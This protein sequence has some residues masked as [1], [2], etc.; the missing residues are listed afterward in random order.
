MPSNSSIIKQLIQVHPVFVDLLTTFFDKRI[1]FLLRLSKSG[2]KM[3]YLGMMT[4]CRSK[5][6]VSQSFKK[7]WPTTIKFSPET[8]FMWDSHTSTRNIQKLCA[9]TQLENPFYIVSKRYKRIGVEFNLT[10]GGGQTKIFS[11]L[12]PKFFQ[13]VEIMKLNLPHELLI[14]I[15]DFL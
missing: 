5:T 9:K 4:I 12:T 8:L 14:M 13:T 1:D 3:P 7:C 2:K 15:I 6:I 10:T 11:K